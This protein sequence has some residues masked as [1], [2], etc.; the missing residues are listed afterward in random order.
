MPQKKEHRIINNI[1]LKECSRCKIWKELNNFTSSPQTSDKKNVYCKNCI[2]IERAEKKKNKK[3]TKNQKAPC[4]ERN[5]E[6]CFERTCAS[7][8]KIMQIWDWEK[9]PKN[10]WEILK[11]T[12]VIIYIFCKI[13]NHHDKKRSSDILRCA[14]GCSYCSDKTKICCDINCTAC[15]NNSFL[16][17]PK[18]NWFD[19]RR[20]PPIDLRFVPKYSNK[21]FHM[22]HPKCGHYIG[23]RSPSSLRDNDKDV[24]RYCR[25]PHQDLCDNK[26]CIIC[27]E[28]S[29]LSVKMAVDNFNKEKSEETIKKKIDLRMI[30]KGNCDIKLCFKCQKCNEEHWATPFSVSRGHWC[31]CDLKFRYCNCGFGGKEGTCPECNQFQHIVNRR[32]MRVR[33]SYKKRNIIGYDTSASEFEKLC[34]MTPEKFYYYLIDTFNFRYNKNYKTLTEIQTNEGRVELDEIIPVYAWNLPNDNKYCWH[35]LNAQLLKLKQ[36]RQKG[37]KF[38]NEDKERKI[39]EIDNYCLRL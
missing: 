32:M 27:F 1:E 20:N 37:N 9:N 10:P 11:K 33:E 34:S 25:K 14:S 8:N 4:G 2:K 29:L 18:L 24:C 38:K 12:S 30:S 35:W 26:K 7:E 39:R 15:F 6:V 19:A 36:N 5:C 16:S 3:C 23:F 31:I 21:C 22:T 13:C 17:H 28:N